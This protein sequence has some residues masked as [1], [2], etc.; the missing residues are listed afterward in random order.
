VQFSDSSDIVNGIINSWDWSFGNG[1]TSSLKNNIIT[2]DTAGTS[3]TTLIVSALNGCKDTIIKLITI[4]E[5][6]VSSFTHTFDCSKDTVFFT[7]TSTV[8][9]GSITGFQWYFGDL[10]SLNYTQNPSHK[11]ILNGFYNVIL[12]ITS[13]NSCSSVFKERISL[14]PG[15]IN[16]DGGVNVDDFLIFAPAVGT[17]CN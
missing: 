17:T 14:L 4:N 11:Y 1:S 16:R 5:P 8:P 9:S 7:N 10:S 2:F 3:A 13:N 15:D 6:P 12:T